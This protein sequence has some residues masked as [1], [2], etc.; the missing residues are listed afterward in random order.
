MGG[1]ELVCTSTESVRA[2]RPSGKSELWRS[3]WGKKTRKSAILHVWRDVKEP[4]S[5]FFC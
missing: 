4:L 1:A 5:F 2:R 3:E